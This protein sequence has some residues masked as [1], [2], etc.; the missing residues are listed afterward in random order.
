MKFGSQLEEHIKTSTSYSAKLYVDYTALKQRIRKRYQHHRAHDILET[1]AFKR[2]LRKAIGTV[3]LFYVKMEAELLSRGADHTTCPQLLSQAND[4]KQYAMLNYV[5]ILKLLKKHDKWCATQLYP[6]IERILV[7]QPF[8][9]ALLSSPLFYGRQTEAGA[10]EDE[11]A[12]AITCGIC[13][14]PRTNLQAL[15]C[16][17][18]FCM[19]CLA[20]AAAAELHACPCCRSPQSL[21]P[22]DISLSQFKISLKYSPRTIGSSAEEEHVQSSVCAKGSAVREAGPAS[23]VTISALCVALALFVACGRKPLADRTGTVE[24]PPHT[25]GAAHIIGFL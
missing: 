12:E 25:S 22:I 14:E 16:A 6:I 20:K 10:M 2:T 24:C 4:L 13:L 3:N 11:C 18:E 9:V 17:H 5:A 23:D 1:A 15:D 7:S 21:H 19:L 8:V